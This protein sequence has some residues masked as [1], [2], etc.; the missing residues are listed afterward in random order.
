M[1]VELYNSYKMKYLE[2]NPQIL[3]PYP[4]YFA[5]GTRISKPATRNETGLKTARGKN[6]CRCFFPDLLWTL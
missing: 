4:W 3:F 6:F 1:C 5:F 2:A